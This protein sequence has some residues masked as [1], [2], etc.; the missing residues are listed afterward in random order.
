MPQDR[1]SLILRYASLAALEMT[2]KDPARLAEIA[3]DKKVIA[4]GLGMDGSAI[5]M[6]ASKLVAGGNGSH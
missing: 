5:I 1:F 3:D 4:D 2:E 6:E